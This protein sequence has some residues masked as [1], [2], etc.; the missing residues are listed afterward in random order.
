MLTI[1][2][3]AN[4]F[5]SAVE[6]YIGDEIN[7][8][9]RRG[10]RVIPG[11]VRKAGTVSANGDLP[12]VI[13]LWPH[14]FVVAEAAWLCLRRWQR[15]APL[16]VRVMF[17]GQESFWQRLKALAHTFLGAC[18]AVRLKNREINHIHAHHGYF[19]S[20][21]AMTAARL[22]DVEFSMTLHGSDL[23]LHGTYLDVKLQ[24]CVLCLTVSEYNRGYILEHYSN[25]E[26]GKVAVVR[27]GVDVK[28]GAAIPTA[29]Y[30]DSS[31][32]FT[33]L[34]VGRLHP[35]K[36]YAFLVEACA[37]LQA[38]DVS[39]ECFIA[40][41]GQER[42]RLKHLIRECDLEDRVTLLGHV[43]REQMDSLY[44]R[45]DVVV[46]TSHS[47][48]I[49]LVL[50]EAM[51]RAKIVLAPAITGIPELVIAGQTGFLYEP[52]S[53]DSFVRRLL[54]I[55]SLLAIDSRVHRISGD[56]PV[57][58]ITRSLDWVRH[59]AK[60]QV[61]HNF[62]RIKNLERFADLFLRRITPQ[63]ESVVDEDLVLQQIQL[64]V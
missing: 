28:S 23:L 40:G 15:V 56:F 51:V 63:I 7:Q 34:A 5:P 8:L 57:S 64:S 27:L 2:Y 62:N 4:E 18:Y 44:A 41:D 60:V 20:W 54:Y 53:I 49:P 12:E 43:P 22:L 14:V 36:N 39:F 38:L 59:G 58:K 42:G 3:L 32:G 37:Q 11:S 24:N 21:I 10:V 13:L 19:G 9:R 47:E 33:V 16:I 17:R 6:P 45:A 26:P 48:G 25:C 1:A 55:R 35:V 31:H 61:S 29:K 50:M 46:L 52:G 30:K